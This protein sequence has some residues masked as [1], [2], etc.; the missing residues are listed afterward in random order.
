M[1]VRMS[2]SRRSQRARGA[3][4]TAAV[5]VALSTA[6]ALPADAASVYQVAPSGSDS[7]VGTASAP[8][9][10]LAKAMSVLRAGDT[11]VVRGGV[12]R[13]RLTGTVA[14]GTATAPVR[15]VAAPGER[16]VVEGLL[17]LSSPDFWTLDGINVTWSSGNSANEHMVKISNGVGWR[18][19]NAEIWGA[20]SYAAVLVAGQPSGWSLD[21]LY[22]HDTYKSNGTNQDH[23]IYVNTGTGGGTIERSVLSG[24][25]NGRGV[26]VG[27]PSGGSTPGG[28]VTIRYNTFYDNTGPSNV[29]LSY[30]AT[31][32]SIY[33]NIMQKSGSAN[34]TAYN[35]N[36]TGNVAQD[37][38]GWES[39][40]VLDVVAGL[41]DAG[42]NQ[43]VDPRFNSTGA[44]GF[45]PQTLA[46]QA[47]GAFAGAAPL[48]SPA[49]AASPL[50]SA[51]A[52]S[53]PTPIASPVL[54][55]SPAPTAAPV[56]SVSAA[57]LT[58]G[59]SRTFVTLAD[60]QV[61]SSSPGTNYGQG[62][63]L[64][65]RTGPD[66]SY[67]TYVRFT[68]SGL[69][70]APAAAT[71]RLLVT[72][73]TQDRVQVHS[74]ASAT[75]SEDAVTWSARPA[76]AAGA[77]A[78]AGG[79]VAGTWLQLALPAGAITGNGTYSFR[80]AG[81]GTDSAIFASR[82]GGSAPQLVI[83]G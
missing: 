18:V 1:S 10:T 29:Q 57:P 70:G 25:Q 13:E 58:V 24:S 81:S 43:R 50:P 16:P 71:L 52:P 40:R 47:Y 54:T 26:K 6:W 61:K 31:G 83:S 35:L 42:G 62:T 33:R 45:R 51:P 72:D 32:N 22:V 7:A 46:A 12:Y 65:I 30:G 55:T 73:G 36:G 77:L 14:K 68:V 78:Q 17:W 82:E 60:A 76:T 59:A 38:I 27:P 28:K 39:T 69:S 80:L 8:F 20:R 37:N 53:S 11:L 34:I 23:L 75:W 3:G 4:L 74:A 64:R 66:V 5:V 19:T 48:A 67:Q 63:T 79:A 49:P 2:S 9:R 21:H 15:V 41:K 44:G 56:P